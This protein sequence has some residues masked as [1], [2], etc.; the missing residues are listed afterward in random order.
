M[1]KKPG[2]SFVAAKSEHID[3]IYS[4]D[5]SNKHQRNAVSHYTMR[6]HGDLLNFDFQK[7][8]DS[9]NQLFRLT[10]ENTVL[11]MAEAVDT[12]C[13]L[14]VRCD[15][16]YTICINCLYKLVLQRLHGSYM[17]QRVFFT[18]HRIDKLHFLVTLIFS[19]VLRIGCFW[20]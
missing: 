15:S 16:I 10:F 2:A 1:L 19:L 13:N 4:H 5:V 20:L 6:L 7:S 12:C 9:S 11:Y 17:R 3:Q 18:V 8:S 14:Y